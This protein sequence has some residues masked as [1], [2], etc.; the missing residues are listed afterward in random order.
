M[1]KIYITIMTKK[2]SAT[3]IPKLF[4]ALTHTKKVN[5]G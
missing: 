5:I 2:I 1:L 4:M 3:E